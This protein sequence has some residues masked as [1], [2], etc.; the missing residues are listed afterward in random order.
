MKKIIAIVCGVLLIASVA[1]AG[2]VNVSS[3]IRYDSSA[4]SGPGLLKMI[5]AGAG[6]IGGSFKVYDGGSTSGRA[7]TPQ[8]GVGTATRDSVVFDFG[9]GIPFIN[10]LYVDVTSDG[11][12]LMLYYETN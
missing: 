1:Y 3:Q 8:L 7:I 5:V 10:G 2:S 11:V 4:Y 12:Y 6:G 9:N